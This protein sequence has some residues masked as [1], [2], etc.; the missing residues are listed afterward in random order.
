MKKFVLLFAAVAIF[1][2]A[3]AQSLSYGIKAG[4]NTTTDL[5]KNGLLNENYKLTDNKAKVG[6][7]AGVF[8]RVGVLGFFVQPELYYSQSRTELT[9]QNIKDSKVSTEISKMN[10]LNIPILFGYK[11]GPARVNLGPV[12][13]IQLSN[14][15][16]IDNIAGLDSDIKTAN[17]GFQ[18]GVGL[19]LLNRLTLDARYEGSLT[20]VGKIYNTVEDKN[21][22]F[23]QR[24]QQFVFSVGIIL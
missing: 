6:F 22:N 2:T 20:K 18:A 13:S 10:M 9:F 14:N 16:I 23:G 1:A 24:P 11:F 19:D 21:I 17:W 12:A 7:Q 15:N 3:N 8:A 4:I 5:F